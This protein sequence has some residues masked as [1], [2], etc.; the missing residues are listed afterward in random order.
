MTPFDLLD[1]DAHESVHF[2]SDPASG[3]EAIVAVH[4][5]TRGPAAGGCRFWSYPDRGAA[6]TDALRLARGMSYKNALAGLPLGGGKAVVL[7]PAGDFDR[8]ALFAAFGRAVESLGGRY[9]TAEDV[10]TTVADMRSIAG[11]TRYVGGLANGAGLAGGDPSPSTAWGVFLGLHEAWSQLRGG[12]GGELA[13]V[14]VAVQ[15]LG[16]VG[17]NLCRQLHAAGARLVVADLDPERLRRAVAEFGATPVAAAEILGADVDILSPCALGA[18]L[19]EA[20]IPRI[21]AALV[22]GAANN[23]LAT[24]EDGERLRRR[25]ILYAPDYVINAGGI[26][27]VACE[28]LRQGSESEVRA[29]IAR[30]PGTLRAVLEEAAREVL[31]THVVADRLAERALRAPGTATLQPRLPRLRHAN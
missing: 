25:G 4:S 28:Y 30:I 16:G 8:A 5:T 9:V 17:Y 22:A 21:R 15:G 26:I 14:R 18:V 23:Q 20:S 11:A 7:R 6:L 31:P 29:H 10:G 19:D 1:F 3:L 13:G 24:P 2:F 12:R 27:R